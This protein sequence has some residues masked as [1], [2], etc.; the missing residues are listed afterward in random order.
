M[1][2]SI[3][4]NWWS[5]RCTARA[6]TECSSARPPA[7]GARHVS[8][9]IADRTYAKLRGTEIKGIFEG[10]LHEFLADFIGDNNR[11]GEQVAQ[12]FGFY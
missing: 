6:V 9:D 1:S 7:S 12:D 3:W 4:P 8:L 5:R 2:R 10:G 11:L